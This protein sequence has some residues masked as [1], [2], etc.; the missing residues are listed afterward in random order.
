M[1]T[2]QSLLQAV[3]IILS[4]I[5]QAPVANLDT[6]NPMVNLAL[7]MINEV[8]SSVQTEGWVFNT[9]QDYPLTPDTNGNVLVP[10]NAITIDLD[11][12]DDRDVVIRNGKLYDKRKH[13]FQFKSQVKA[14]I[15]WLFDFADLPEPLKTM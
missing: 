6:P 15:T 10:E 13:T 14:T 1:A 12:L 8:S 2:K 9:E 11:R 7:G 3:N 4:N 5:G